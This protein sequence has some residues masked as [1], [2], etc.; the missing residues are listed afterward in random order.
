MTLGKEDL[1]HQFQSKFKDMTVPTPMP[2][3][4]DVKPAESVVPAPTGPSV[5]IA[6]YASKGYHLD[7]TFPS[8]QVPE[9][10]EL[11]DRNGFAIDTITGVDWIAQDRME[12]V[13][14]FFHPKITLRV[15]V[16]TQVPRSHPQLPTISKVFPGADWH[17]RETHDFFGI[18]FEGHPNLIPI[19][20]PED[21]T[22]HPLK[23]DFVA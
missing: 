18:R 19:L 13:Y 15:M 11:L 12:I 10:A 4:A 7:F 1:V 23:K 5:S 21:A 8:A 16:R 22:F 6:D 3:T 9:A 14:D 2:V 20:L 17:E